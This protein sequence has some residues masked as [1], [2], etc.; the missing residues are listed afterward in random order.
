MVRLVQASNPGATPTRSLRMETGCMRRIGVGEDCSPI[1]ILFG[2]GEQVVI[3]RG[4]TEFRAGRPLIAARRQHSVERHI[5][6]YLDHAAGRAGADHA[7]RRVDVRRHKCAAPDRRCPIGLEHG[8]NLQ[9]IGLEPRPR[10]AAR[11]GRH[12]HRHQHGDDGEHADDL[13][14]RKAILAAC[15]V[16]AS[17]S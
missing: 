1:S 2:P 11:H 17:S 12:Q 9:R 13:E 10:C 8:G 7:R 14:Q 16:M 3:G 4:L 5:V 6:R 15:A